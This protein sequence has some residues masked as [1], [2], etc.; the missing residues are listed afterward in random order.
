MDKV[1]KQIA[2]KFNISRTVRVSKL[3]NGLI[4]DTYLVKNREGNFVLQK[5]HPIF[6]TTVLIDIDNI[7]SYLHKDRQIT[8]LLIKTKDEKLYFKSNDGRYWRMFT[9][10]SGIC[11][12][13]GINS[14][15]AF[16]AGQLVGRFHNI[17]SNFDYKFKHKIKNF[18]NSEAHIK[19]LKQTLK[20]FKGTEKYKS[21]NNLA[22]YV[23][24][25]Y[26]KININLDL[27]PDRIIHGDL[28]INNI[29]FNKNGDAVC[30]LDLDTL[31]RSKVVMDISE[32]TRT[33]CNTG[34]E[35]DI[36]NS[37]FDLKVFESMLRGYLDTAKPI[38]KKELILIPEA[39]KRTLLVLMARF[40]T[41]AFEEKYFR[42]DRHKYKNLYE[43][44][45]TKANA[46]RTLYNDFLNKKN[47]VNKVIRD[48]M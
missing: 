19:N 9:Y 3:G 27:I 24:Q 4:N 10:I 34:N 21:L 28:K 20:K 46:Q 16:S 38:T 48:L 35:D 30:L 15:Q 47:H 43:Q 42:L 8:P 31:S 41:D 25:E 40:I 36:K 13:V 2:N 14:Q 12:E 26:N 11:Y 23:L 45:R 44:N 39:I 5:L 18:K 7:T 22:D 37:S 17:L 1:M 32:A 29:R 6:K 33:W